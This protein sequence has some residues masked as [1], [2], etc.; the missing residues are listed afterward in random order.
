[1]Y[2]TAKLLSCEPSEIRAGRFTQGGVHISFNVPTM[3]C[4]QI[5]PGKRVRINGVHIKDVLMIHM[6][7][8]YFIVLIKRFSGSFYNYFSCYYSKRFS[9]SYE[10]TEFFFYNHFDYIY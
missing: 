1:M 7:T 4:E 9:T 10:L 5:E 3:Y 2:H 8:I 6:F